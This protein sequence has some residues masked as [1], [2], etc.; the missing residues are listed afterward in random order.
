[1]SK[2]QETVIKKTKR[3][4]TK[5]DIKIGLKKLGVN[6]ESKLEVHSSLSSFGY[7]INRE[8]DIIDALLEVVSSGVIIMPAHTSEYGDP[9][10]WENP[11]V[12]KE[13]IP[14][15][16]NNRRP[17]DKEIFL[18]ER[19]GKV[20][21]TFFRYPNVV[22]TNH[23]IE[24]YAVYNQTGDQTWEDH[25]LDQDEEKHPLLKLAK[26]EGKILFLGTDFQ[27][28]SSIHLTE[29]YAGKVRTVEHPF[30]RMEDGQVKERTYKY[31]EFDDDEV[32]NFEEIT[33]RYLDEYQGTPYYKQVKIGLATCTLIDAEALYEV[34][35]EFHKDHKKSTSND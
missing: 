11:P 14:I 13:W 22:R 34:A 10:L 8:Y 32:D 26:E 2:T 6:Q 28:C 5:E 27:T 30:L 18:P 17:F 33:K 21:I 15:I 16:L 9:T 29:K 3:P 4:I 31:Y 1:M 23:P 7:I 24:S 20:P 35:Y 19:V 12:P 25:S